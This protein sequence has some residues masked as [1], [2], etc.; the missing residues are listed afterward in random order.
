MPRVIRGMTR[1]RTREATADT[2]IHHKADPTITPITS[3]MAGCQ[4]ESTRRPSPANTA[5]NE[6]MVGGFVSVSA[7]IDA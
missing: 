1:T 6:R 4:P 2:R 7:T 3:A 5:L